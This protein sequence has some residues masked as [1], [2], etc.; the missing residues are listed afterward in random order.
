M[1]REKYRTS[2]LGRQLK[3]VD[4]FRFYTVDIEEEE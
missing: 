2:S 3:D 4:S 1:V